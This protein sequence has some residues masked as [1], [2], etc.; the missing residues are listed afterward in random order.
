MVDNYPNHEKSIEA[1][2][3]WGSYLCNVVNQE[4]GIKVLW[5]VRRKGSQTA[6]PHRVVDDALWK[7]IWVQRH[8]KRTDK[9]IE[10]LVQLLKFYSESDYYRKDEYRQA[11]YRKA[12][13][14]WLGRFKTPNNR[15][16]AIKYFHTVLK[17]YSNDYYGHRAKEQLIKL[18]VTV[19]P[20][21]VGNRK[22][23][24]PVDRLTDPKARENPP[25]AYLRAIILKSLGLY[26][27]AAEELE[28]LSELK[29]ESGIQFA[30][31]D[32]YA[33]AGNTWSAIIIINRY[34]REFL[35]AGSPDPALV[36]MDFWYIVYPFHYRQEI[37]TAIKESQHHYATDLEPYII[38][39]LIRTES[40]F[41]PR[42]IS[43]VG[44]IG[45][46]QLMPATA[47]RMVK[48]VK[49][50]ELNNISRSE[51]FEPAMNIRLGTLHFA[52]RVNDFK[53]DWYPAICSYNAGVGPVKRW[54]EKKPKNQ[55]LDEFFENILYLETRKYIKRVISAHDNYQRIYPEKTE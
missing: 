13:L 25:E 1:L 20:K 7:I 48:Q 55:P 51:L 36:P 46:M 47:N 24:P 50:D 4:E 9:A 34:F 22:P 12:A 42:A 33:R 44:A 37:N 19:D 14:Y 11:G 39:A 53:G 31:A 38:A 32:L 43:P 54:W 21:Q 40:L 15:R 45:L 52:E 5:Q 30:L 8:L 10:T 26:E 6:T 28:S 18:G 29:E 49:T 2:Y 41:Y 17:E 27:L 16:E 35:L 3:N 23:F